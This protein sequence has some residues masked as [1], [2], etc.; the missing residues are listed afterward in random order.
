MVPKG[1][2]IH[3]QIILDMVLAQMP[4][5]VKGREVSIPLL[6]PM[7]KHFLIQVQILRVVEGLH[8]HPK[9]IR[10]MVVMEIIAIEIKTEEV[11]PVDPEL[12]YWELL[13]EE[14]LVLICKNRII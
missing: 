14:D 12:D 9:F 11:R 1:A 7:P 3:H 6:L 8:Q 5:A 2:K 13:L 10:G 4:L